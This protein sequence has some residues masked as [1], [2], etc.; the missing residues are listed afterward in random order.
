MKFEDHVK[1]EIQ[2]GPNSNVL[3]LHSLYFQGLPGCFLFWVCMKAYLL[4]FYSASVQLLKLLSVCKTEHCDHNLSFQGNLLI[5]IQ[6]SSF[7]WGWTYIKKE[8]HLHALS[9]N[10]FIF[11]YRL[12]HSILV[13]G[14]Q[15]GQN[16]GPSY[17]VTHKWPQCGNPMA[18]LI[19]MRKSFKLCDWTTD[20]VF[21]EKDD[22]RTS[23]SLWK[24]QKLNVPPLLWVVWN[25]KSSF[26]CQ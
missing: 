6:F 13:P 23:C 8:Y 4:P 15:Q 17:T 11:P 22:V 1:L 21:H 20:E 25:S 12:W 9:H 7:N 14:V 26:L 3:I 24:S 10:L 19:Q 16:H 5:L 18:F 2:A